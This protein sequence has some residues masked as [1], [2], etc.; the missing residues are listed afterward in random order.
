[1]DSGFGHIQGDWEQCELR[2]TVGASEVT[3]TIDGNAVTIP[4]QPVSSINGLFFAEND[5]LSSDAFVD[6][7]LATA[8]LGDL[9]DTNPT[10]VATRSGGQLILSWSNGVGYVLQENS[11]LNNPNGWE[12]VPNGGISPVQV[13]ISGEA[14]FYRLAK[15]L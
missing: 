3:M 2:Y 1:V 8:T 7:V 10:L 12:T 9:S 11:D 13:P 5:A 15:P 14:V 6:D 4:V